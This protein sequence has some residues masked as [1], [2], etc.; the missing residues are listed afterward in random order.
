M[1]GMMKTCTAIAVL[2]ALSQIPTALGSTESQRLMVDG[3]ADPSPR[4]LSA[5]FGL[6]NGLPFIANRLCLGASGE[7]GMPVVL[8]QTVDPATL[9]PEDF[10]VVRQSGYSST[11]MCVTLRPAFDPGET[12]TVLLI[13]EFGDATDDPPVHVQ[14]VDDLMSDAANGEAANFRGAQTDVIALD[15][16][17]T[18]VWAE[19]VS[20]EIWSQSGRGTS[21]PSDTQQ[22]VRVT[23]TGGVRLP[24]GEEPGDTERGLYRVTLQH[25]D[26]STSNV[27]PASLAELG[28]NDNNHFLCLDT[29]LPATVVAFPAGH[30]V[31]PNG[32]LN[33]NSHVAVF[34]QTR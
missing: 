30:L 5:F 26:G 25:A 22:V 1:I 10:R 24:D 12:R 31:D 15:A 7:D 17:P 18:L 9:Q 32:D 29:M 16:G 34:P 2:A 13:G 21:C 3:A 27:S 33:P 8:S 6:D 28:D 11:P 20:R 19:V 14:V 23:W 4:L